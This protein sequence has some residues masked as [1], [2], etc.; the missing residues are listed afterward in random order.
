MLNAFRQLLWSSACLFRGRRF[1]RKKTVKVFMGAHRYRSSKKKIARKAHYFVRTDASLSSLR[2]V[3]QSKYVEINH[4]VLVHPE[5]HLD[6][7]LSE[8]HLS[9][10]LKQFKGRNDFFIETIEMPEEL[11]GLECGLYGPLLGD[12]PIPESEVHYAPRNGRKGPSRLVPRP[13]RET[14]LLTVIAGP[15]EDLDCILYTA[16]GGPHGAAREPWDTEEGTK[17]RQQSE[18]FWAQHALSSM[19]W[20][21]RQLPILTATRL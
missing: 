21:A 12:D 11:P 5:S 3:C 2:W 13:K 18:Q 14:R 7:G 20:T 17:E 6:H 19:D 15:H 1:G 16:Y 10:I 4:M 9:Y 8:V